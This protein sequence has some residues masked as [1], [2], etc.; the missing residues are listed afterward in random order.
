MTAE[1]YSSCVFVCV[2]MSCVCIRVCTHTHVL[3]SSALSYQEEKVKPATVG[4]F[5]ECVGSCAVPN[6]HGLCRGAVF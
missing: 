6:A 5:H 1:K 3:F 4:I 2:S